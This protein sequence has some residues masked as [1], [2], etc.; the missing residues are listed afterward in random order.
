M[1]SSLDAQGNKLICNN[2]GLLIR[3]EAILKWTYLQPNVTLQ[4]K[5]DIESIIIAMYQKLGWMFAFEYVKGH[6]DNSIEIKNLPLDVQLNVEA[7][8]LATEY[9]ATSQYQGRVSLFLSVDTISCKLQNAIRYQAGLGPTQTYVMARNTWSDQTMRSIDWQAHGTAH[10][11]H[12]ASSSNSAI[13]TFHWEKRITD[14]TANT[15]QHAQDA[16]RSLKVTIIFWGVQQN[17]ASKGEPNS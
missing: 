15:Q 5:W 16:E 12:N 4:S 13:G 7:D 6:Q 17:P 1:G 14:G 11:H 2:E 10:L 8:Q 3:I 9:L